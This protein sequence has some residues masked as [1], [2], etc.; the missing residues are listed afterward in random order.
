V[1]AESEQEE[2][3]DENWEKMTN[4]QLI[5]A[6][7]HYNLPKPKKLT[8]SEY[9]KTLK[10]H[11]ITLESVKYVS[12]GSAS[13]KSKVAVPQ[14]RSRAKESLVREI[15][16]DGNQAAHGMDEDSEFLGGFN[17]IIS[18][19]KT[20]TD[21]A[22]DIK[23][24]KQMAAQLNSAVNR[25]IETSKDNSRP[26]LVSNGL[27]VNQCQPQAQ[28]V[29]SPPAPSVFQ[30]TQQQNGYP[31]SA[32]SLSFPFLGTSI[33]FQNPF[34][35][36]KSE[37]V[38]K[39]SLRQFVELTEFLDAPA[40]SASDAKTL[41]VSNGGFVQLSS[42][43]TT[44]KNKVKTVA[45]LQEA[46]RRFVRVHC[47]YFPAERP[48]LDEYADVMYRF[49][50][51]RTLESCII[52][53]R[54]TRSKCAALSQP[55]QHNA[56]LAQAHLRDSSTKANACSHCGSFHHKSDECNEDVPGAHGKKRGLNWRSQHHPK[57][58]PEKSDEP[59][60]KWNS[61]K[62]CVRD[63]CPFRHVCLRCSKEGHPAHKCKQ[64]PEKKAA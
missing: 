19:S 49:T 12:E 29:T 2:F 59:C 31:L 56:I 64:A 51:S 10:D 34:P 28:A 61:G 58:L 53:D 8:K 18:E 35:E 41:T 6:L 62:P 33:S 39:V 60:K 17:D 3:S 54:Q 14:N 15:L 24:L 9:I 44:V 38:K 55:I 32:S 43:K 45:D 11:K 16:N 7:E 25:L 22:P 50:A 13:P 42:G 40:L 1:A 63:N 46:F 20:V 52:Y 47:H 30:G 23:Q 37:L 21:D 26:Q 5:D 36:H 48:L 4:K 27:G 57:P